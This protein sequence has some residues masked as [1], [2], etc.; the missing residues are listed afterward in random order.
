MGDAVRHAKWLEPEFAR[1]LHRIAPGASVEARALAYRIEDGGAHAK[2]EQPADFALFLDNGRALHIECK[3][4]AWGKPF[5][6][7][8]IEGHQIEWLSAF[9]GLDIDFEGWV[10]L[11]WRC[12]GK[13]AES[14]LCMV[15]VADLS[16][17]AK[18]SGRRSVPMADA[19]EMGMVLPRG[20]DDAPGGRKWW[21]DL[22]PVEEVRP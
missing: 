10:A 17:Y 13:P 6:L 15:P 19:M 4:T 12:P 9:D 14:V 7:R 11:G 8:R 20:F 16:R 2:N 22:R 3:E 5:E 21:W 1:S 18:E